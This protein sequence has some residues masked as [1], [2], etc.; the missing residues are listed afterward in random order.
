MSYRLQLPMGAGGCVPGHV[1][2]DEAT[3]LIEEDH[4]GH[5]V[6]L[7]LGTKVPHTRVVEGQLAPRHASNHLVVVGLGCVRACKHDLNVGLLHRLHVVE[8]GIPVW[9]TLSQHVRQVQRR[10]CADTRTAVG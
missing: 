6:H 5:R 10:D 3:P 2:A 1:T 8:E 4:C 9:G 7:I